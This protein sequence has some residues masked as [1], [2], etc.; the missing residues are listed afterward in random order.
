MVKGP[1]ISL[2]DKGDVNKDLHNNPMTFEQNPVGFEHSSTNKDVENKNIRLG[3]ATLS[4]EETLLLFD[5]PGKK[6]VDR[7]NR[8]AGAR[9]QYSL[10][11]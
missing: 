5:L 2:P 10:G 6:R 1:Q 11:K 4:S 7:I 8:S 3:E 9:E